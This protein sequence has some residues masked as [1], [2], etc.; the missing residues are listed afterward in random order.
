MPDNNQIGMGENSPHSAKFI[1]DIS[2]FI[3]S[4]CIG[5]R[6]KESKSRTGDILV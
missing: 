2:S 1:N 6:E 4:V 3:E 5:M